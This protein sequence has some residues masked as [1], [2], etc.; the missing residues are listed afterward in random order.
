MSL[1]CSFDATKNR[2]YI[3]R[4]KDCIENFCKPLKELGTEIISYTEKKLIPLT[5]KENM[6]YEEQ[7]RNVIYGKKS[8]V[9][10]D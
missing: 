6:L 10:I 3:Y 5:D 4:G 2:H 9:Q 1:I 7:K 8:F